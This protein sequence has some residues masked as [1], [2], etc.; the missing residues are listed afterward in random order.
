MRG[1]ARRR[2]CRS[3][4]A[5]LVVFISGCRDERPPAPSA[6][7]SAAPSPAVAAVQPT[8]MAAAAEFST[9]LVSDES[10]QPAREDTATAASVRSAVASG[11]IV[12]V[13]PGVRR[14]DHLPHHAA[15]L[16]DQET[17]YAWPELWELDFDGPI[18]RHKYYVIDATRL[19]VPLWYQHSSFHTYHRMG[20]R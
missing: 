7:P 18:P 20:L 2:L 10:R 11:R 8:V 13:R 17:F 6:A 1:L 15:E 3:V 12:L 9:V 16:L 14:T 4:S 5:L 19:S